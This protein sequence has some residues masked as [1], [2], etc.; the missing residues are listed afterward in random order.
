M[1]SQRYKKGLTRLLEPAALF[2]QKHSISPNQLTFFG[3]ISS[4]LSAV[5]Y[6]SGHLRLGGIIL[7]LS[8][9]S[10]V[11]DGSLA[12]NTGTSSAFGAFIDSVSDRYA[13]LLVYFGILIQL[14][15]AGDILHMIV[16]MA[17]MLGS[18]MVSY[19]RA[20]AESIIESC[21][22]GFM[23][24]PERL[25]TIVIF[26]LIGHIEPALWILAVGANI[27]ALQRIIH[28]RRNT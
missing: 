10:D 14:H 16:L 11:L 24:R 27:T 12:R 22:V 15:F 20:R 13:D 1:L 21:T 3:L 28:T 5:A 18:V 4:F 7:L 17:A 25:L 19:T 9:I 26:S 2:L 6:A 23:E 8:G